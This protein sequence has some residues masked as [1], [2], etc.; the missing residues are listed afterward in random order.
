M[1]TVSRPSNVMTSI[2]LPAAA[3]GVD[4]EAMAGISSGEIGWD[5]FEGSFG[6]VF[7]SV[8]CRSR[9]SDAALSLLMSI[10]SSSVLQVQMR[11]RITKRLRGRGVIA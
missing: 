5:V 7:S 8:V 10:T 4:L 6:E 11:L 9:S 3:D 1:F 2:S